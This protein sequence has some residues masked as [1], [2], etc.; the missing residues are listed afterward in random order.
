M[1]VH[2]SLLPKALHNFR[3]SFFKSHSG[4]GDVCDYKR[5]HFNDKGDEWFLIGTGLGEFWGAWFGF[6]PDCWVVGVGRYCSV[7]KVFVS[8][9]YAGKWT[10]REHPEMKEEERNI[11]KVGN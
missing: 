7:W 5:L 11:M 1:A 2:L 8:C 10:D 6:V 4:S 9:L 3:G